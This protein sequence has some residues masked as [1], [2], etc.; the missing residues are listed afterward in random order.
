MLH[1]LASFE[2]AGPSTVAQD[3]G[4]ALSV[5]AREVPQ[6]VLLDLELP[7]VHGL[8]VLRYLRREPRFQ[9][10]VVVVTGTRGDSG[11]DRTGFLPGEI[12]MPKPFGPDDLDLAIRIA[13]ARITPVHE[14]HNSGRSA[15]V[16]AP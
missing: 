15:G 5:L 13:R 16:S 11:C 2:D 8:E 12:W 1:W 10:T 7:L 9:R 4:E 3:G 14:A 6:L